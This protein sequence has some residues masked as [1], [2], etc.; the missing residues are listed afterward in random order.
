MVALRTCNG[1]VTFAQGDYPGLIWSTL[2]ACQRLIGR[3]MTM[4]AHTARAI[5]LEST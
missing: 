4:L 5:L 1:C 3:R 2:S